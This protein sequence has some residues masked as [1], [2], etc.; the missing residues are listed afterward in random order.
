MNISV[1]AIAM[2]AIT[3]VAASISDLRAFRISNIFPAIIIVLFVVF[4]AISGFSYLLLPNFLHFLLAL[5]VGMLLFGKGWIGGG[6]AKLYAVVALWFNWNGAVALIFLTTFSGLLLAIAFVV[7]RMLGI[8]RNRAN[9]DKPKTKMERR[10]PY[11]VAIALG[12][13][14]TASWVGW[15]AVFPFV[16]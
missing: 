7:G 5:A 11:G 14:L 8:R 12:A 15:T 1:I 3:L 4:H 9:T 16:G 10:I 2:W 13:V 6:D